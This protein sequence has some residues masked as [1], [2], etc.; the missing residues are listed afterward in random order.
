MQ[1]SIQQSLRNSA[2]SGVP[3]TDVVSFQSGDRSILGYGGNASSW[4]PD[5]NTLMFGEV[6]RK[7]VP[8]SLGVDE[9][10][11]DKPLWEPSNRLAMLHHHNQQF[12]YAAAR[13]A[14]ALSLELRQAI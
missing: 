10:L 5:A 12:Q 6:G 4:R 1:A 7:N 9:L 3:T 11:P 2:L 8:L 13:F 14:I